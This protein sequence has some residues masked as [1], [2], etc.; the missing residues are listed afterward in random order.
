MF[1]FHPRTVHVKYHGVFPKQAYL[2]NQSSVSLHFRSWH[3][4]LLAKFCYELR[5]AFPNNQ[6][7]YVLFFGVAKAF[8]TITQKLLLVKL[9]KARFTGSSFQLLN[10]FRADSRQVIAVDN[11]SSLTVLHRAGA[12]P[13]CVLFPTLF[14]TYV[15]DII[16]CSSL[17]EVFIFGDVMLLLSRHLN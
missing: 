7:A 6:V 16:S 9:Y 15:N 13:G 8:D 11:I 4:S 12:T 17:F 14:N 5:H 1:I 10:R 3:P 2:Y